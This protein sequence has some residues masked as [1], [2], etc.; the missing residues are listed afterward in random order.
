MA[1]DNEDQES[2]YGDEYGDAGDGA[3]TGWNE[4]ELGPPLYQRAKR[5]QWTSEEEQKL[6]RLAGRYAAAGQ[7]QV[8]RTEE[9]R[10][11]G[12]ARGRQAGQLA[13]VGYGVRQPVSHDVMQ[14]GVLGPRQAATQRVGAGD[15]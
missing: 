6:A 10:A 13:T 9:Q 4:G 15:A 8:A 1:S 11:R 5:S 14:L 2:E 3:Q 12:R 7:R